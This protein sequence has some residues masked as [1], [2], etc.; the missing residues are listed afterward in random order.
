MDI[1]DPKTCEV[2]KSRKLLNTVYLHIWSIVM[3][4]GVD[5][6]RAKDLNLRIT[7]LQA[8]A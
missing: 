5:W 1:D 6:S 2:K 4:S 3:S 8:V 7:A